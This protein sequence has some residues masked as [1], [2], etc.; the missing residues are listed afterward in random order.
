MIYGELAQKLRLQMAG[1]L[2]KWPRK[3]IELWGPWFL[4]TGFAGI[5]IWEE[6]RGP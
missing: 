1:T 3:E 2:Q 6:V 5:L 4:F